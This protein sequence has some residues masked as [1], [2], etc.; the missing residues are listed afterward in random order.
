VSASNAASEV[1]DHAA[2]EYRL[3]LAE[4]ITGQSANRSLFS[5]K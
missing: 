2:P 5:G 1:K 3:A 4:E